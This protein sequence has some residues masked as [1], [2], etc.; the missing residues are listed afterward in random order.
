LKKTLVL[1]L[2]IFILFT[3]T[4]F[5]EVSLRCEV[6]K[7]TISIGE[8]LVYK[9]I[10]R[11]SEKNLPTPKLPKFDGFKIISQAQSS[12]VVYG[13]DSV[14][15]QLAYTYILVPLQPG[16]FTFEP[17]TVM[18]QGKTHACEEVKIEVTED[19]QRSSRKLQKKV[20][21]LP[22]KGPSDSKGPQLT[23]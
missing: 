13:P 16:N 7:K 4:V 21:P 9:L 20:N 12:A 11:Y 14:K 8:Q 3:S 22:D 2:A 23:L 5:A 6:D 1:F 15:N 19:N 17:S 18:I 10:I